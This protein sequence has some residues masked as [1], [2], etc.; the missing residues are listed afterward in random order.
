MEMSFLINGYTPVG[1]LFLCA[2]GGRPL[3]PLPKPKYVA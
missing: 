2:A 1:A 3:L